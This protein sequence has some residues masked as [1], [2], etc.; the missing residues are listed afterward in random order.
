V[1]ASIVIRTFNEAR[2]LPELLL[3]ITEQSV[4]A[5]DREV[6]VV[7]SGSTDPTLDIARRH[8]CGLVQ[9]KQADFSFGRSLNRGCEAARG[10]YLVFVSGHCVPTGPEW[11]SDLLRPFSASEVAITY[12]RQEGGPET[13]FSEHMLFAKYFP[14]AQLPPP[15]DFFCNNANAALRHDDWRRH[16][17]DESLTGLEDMHLARR[18]VNEGRR[19]VYVPSASVFHYHHESWRKIRLRYEREA[20]ALQKIMPEVH[21]SALDALRYFVAGVLGDWS[22]AVSQRALLRHAV[23]IACFRFSQYYGSWR[24]N[25]IHRQLSRQAREKYF[26]PR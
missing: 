19:V 7:D 12:G 21:V 14:A 17:F 2:Y 5:A 24:G 6:I 23:P 3:S 10:R 26:Y 13:Q 9:I 1:L 16:H 22:K 11:L 8:N 25:H 20:I 15:S 4:P 18:L